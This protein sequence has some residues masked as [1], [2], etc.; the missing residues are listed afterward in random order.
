MSRIDLGAPGQ[1]IHGPTLSVEQDLIYDMLNKHR[2]LIFQGAGLDTTRESTG[3][4]G[5]EWLVIADPS[6][7][8]GFLIYPGM[9]IDINDNLIVNP[10]T[11]KIYA[12]RTPDTPGGIP[13]VGSPPLSHVINFYV[14]WAYRNAELGTFKAYSAMDIFGVQRNFIASDSVDTESLNHFQ[15][16][17]SWMEVTGGSVLVN[18]KMKVI[19]NWSEDLVEVDVTDTD[20]IEFFFPLTIG[21]AE[22]GLTIYYIG[23]WF[24]PHYPVAPH[25]EEIIMYDYCLIRATN[26]AIP[27]NAIVLMTVEFDL[28][29]FNP[30]VDWPG[31]ISHCRFIDR[32]VESLLRFNPRFEKHNIPPKDVINLSYNTGTL[33]D[34]PPL[35]TFPPDTRLP[36]G[37]AGQSDPPTTGWVSLAWG[38]NSIRTGSVGWINPITYSATHQL[39][40]NGLHSFTGASDGSLIGYYVVDAVGAVFEIQNNVGDN[41]TIQNI[42]SVGGTDVPDLRTGGSM[43][44]RTNNLWPSWTITVGADQYIIAAITQMGNG[45][46][47][48]REYTVD[49]RGRIAY[50]QIMIDGLPY[51]R[52]VQFEIM[53]VNGFDRI[54][55]SGWVG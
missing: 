9:A 10:L 33:L 17:Y 2:K 43:D 14:K 45:F 48:I 12:T 40:I 30:I 15:Q 35:P 44:G 6:D 24:R 22:R 21:N 29:H 7:P 46:P 19:R 23:D 4:L 52:I 34:I 28:A 20:G 39:T 1:R 47:L 41:L 32:R 3:E 55:N 18:K 54:G 5:N 42:I 53:A 26:G 50:Q 25:R 49:T 13:I 37:L 11:K 36:H 27:A 31:T 51:G 38:F 16:G 8:M